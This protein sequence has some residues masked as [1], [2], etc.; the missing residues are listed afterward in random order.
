[1]TGDTVA[2]I[3]AIVAIVGT[4]LGTGTAQL[5]PACGKCDAM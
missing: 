2:I 1:M 5:F 4:G 3:V